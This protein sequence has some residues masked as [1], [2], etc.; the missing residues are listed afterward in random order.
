MS[1]TGSDGA[2]VHVVDDDAS[3]RSSLDRLFRSVGL[4]CRTYDSAR[5]FLGAEREDRPGCI[6]AD[7]RLPG[8][9]GLDF[10]AHLATEGMGLPIILMTGHGDI[11]MSVRAMKAGAVDF[12]AK[13][14][15]D[16]DIL[17]AV[18][19]AIDRDRA[20]RAI[21]GDATQVRTHLDTLSARQREV[22][23]SVLDGKLNKQVASDLGISEVTVKIHRGAAM[24]KMGARTLVELARML[25]L[26]K[27]KAQGR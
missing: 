15:R 13:P 1:K 19:V 26:I 27:P 7:V 2:V 25:D 21:D 20:R 12:L 9:S 8:M 16:Q 6:V 3:Q 17:D 18:V 14:F 24:R 23:M 10:Q 4:A 22:M 11:P 5:A